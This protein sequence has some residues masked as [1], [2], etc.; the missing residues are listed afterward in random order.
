MTAPVLAEAGLPAGFMSMAN[1][2]PTARP[3]LP[4]LAAADAEIVA[5]MTDPNGFQ[6]LRFFIP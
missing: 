5:A 1:A 4:T 6:A 2:G 3:R